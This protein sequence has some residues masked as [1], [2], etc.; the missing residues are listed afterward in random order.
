MFDLN[1]EKVMLTSMII[2]SG[3][4][5]SSTLG[6]ANAKLDGGFNSSDFVQ[7]FVAGKYETRWVDG[8]RQDP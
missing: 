7:V 5:S 1:D 3:S 2:A 8:A 4:R 6:L